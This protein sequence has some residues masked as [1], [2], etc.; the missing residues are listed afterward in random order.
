M[1]CNSYY[2]FFDTIS[3]STR[4]SIIES[5][6]KGDKSVGEIS[7]DIKEEQSKVSHSLKRLLDCN[8][9]DVKREGKKRVYSLN[10]ET[11]VPILNLVDKH[12]SKFCT[13]ECKQVKK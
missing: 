4:R 10:K 7:L 3:N 6:L 5:L 8:F 12:V 9:L 1:K 11:V 13:G 2:M